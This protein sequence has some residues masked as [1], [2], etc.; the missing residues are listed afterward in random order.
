M[1]ASS[2]Q[3]QITSATLTVINRCLPVDVYKVVKNIFSEFPVWMPDFQ[4][5]H[6]NIHRVLK[7][8]HIL[9]YVEVSGQTV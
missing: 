6:F 1:D 5:F 3:G 4:T 9:K 7:F 8:H 2:I